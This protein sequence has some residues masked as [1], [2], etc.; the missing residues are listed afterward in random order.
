MKKDVALDAMRKKKNIDV[1]CDA[2]RVW[3]RRV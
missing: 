3:K 2:M 1:A